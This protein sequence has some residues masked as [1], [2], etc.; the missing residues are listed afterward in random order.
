MRRISGYLENTDTDNADTDN[1]DTDSTDTDNADT[2][3]ADTDNADKADCFNIS[4]S[5]GAK[6]IYLSIYLYVSERLK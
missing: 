5:F 1:A 3:N 4:A 2:D 6:N